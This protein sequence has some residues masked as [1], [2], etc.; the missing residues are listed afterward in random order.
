MPVGGR[1][2]HTYRAAGNGG[3]MVIVVPDLDLVVAFTGGNYN[4]GR[5]WW[6]WNDDFVPNVLIPA[7]D[8]H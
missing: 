5:V 4:Q 2:Y 1:V 7:V 8:R 6:R 3:Q